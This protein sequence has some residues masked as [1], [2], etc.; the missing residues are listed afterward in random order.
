MT[1][2]VTLSVIRSGMEWDITVDE[3]ETTVNVTDLLPGNDYIIRISAVGIDG[4]TSPP[5][6]PLTPNTTFPGDFIHTAALIINPY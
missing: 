6:T 2:G 1:A 3:N 5:S 4:Q